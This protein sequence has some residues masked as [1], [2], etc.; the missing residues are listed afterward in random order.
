MPTRTTTAITAKDILDEIKPLG[1]DGYRRILAN[2]GI[3]EPCYGVKIE[4][5]KKIQK[6][7]KTNYQLALDLFD[8]GVYD[9]MYLAGLIA[10][11]AKMTRKDLQRWLENANSPTI[12]GYTVAWV[13]AGSNHG[14]ELALEWIDSK[15]PEAAATGWSTLSNLVALKDD[16]DL[17][18]KELRQLLQRVATTIHAQPDRVR[19]TM[20]GF[21]IAL[22]SSVKSL[23]ADALAAAKKIGKVSVDMGDTACKVPDATAY[24]DKIKQRGAIGKKRKSVKC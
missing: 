14:R 6:R 3:Q 17:D 19:Y 10:D 1:S 2:H 22:G 24:I 4:Y 7:V 9:A 18:L 13:A 20:N 11:D 21:V 5:L 23:T 16:A 15:N 12:C 8:T